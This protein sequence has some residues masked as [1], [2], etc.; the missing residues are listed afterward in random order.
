MGSDGVDRRDAQPTVDAEL[1][2]FTG[3]HARPFGQNFGADRGRGLAQREGTARSHIRGRLWEIRLK[4]KA[5]IARAL[6]R[7]REGAACGDPQGF[8]QKTEKTPAGEIDLALPTGKGTEAMTKISELHRG[9]SK[10]ADYKD[11]YDALG[12]SSTSLRH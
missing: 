10:H 8:H 1:V 12:E 9:W 11:A 2:E 6:Y 4:G 5:G 3:G 7:H